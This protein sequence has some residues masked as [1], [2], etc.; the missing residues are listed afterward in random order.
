VSFDRIAVI[1]ISGSGKSTFARALGARTSL[2]VLHGDRLDW[3]ENWGVR[4]AAELDAM[5]AEWLARPR[6]IIEG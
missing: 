3:M 4:P 1:G 6:W 2:P 5:H